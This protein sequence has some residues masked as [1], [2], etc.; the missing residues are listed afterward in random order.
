MV[1]AGKAAG[2]IDRQLPANCTRI[3]ESRDDSSWGT[4]DEP[5]WTK[6]SGRCG[7][8]SRPGLLVFH[9]VDGRWRLVTTGPAEKPE[10]PM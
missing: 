5:L 6:R 2:S 4:I 9:R 7:G 1:A 3:T 10:Q 8:R